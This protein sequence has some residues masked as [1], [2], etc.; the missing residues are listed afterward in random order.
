MTEPAT[1]GPT[2]TLAQVI[3]SIVNTSEVW[4]NIVSAGVILDVIAGTN[5]PPLPPFIPDEI[6]SGGV[7]NATDYLWGSGDI[8]SDLNGFPQD[9]QILLPKL[10]S[11]VDN[12]PISLTDYMQSNS[13]VMDGFPA[14]WQGILP[15]LKSYEDAHPESKV[16]LMNYIWGDSENPPALEGFPTEWQGLMPELK[17]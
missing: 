9:W 6:P 3:C 10:K 8:P 7:E 15:E 5:K 16:Q 4:A 2:K 11:Y 17:T 14:E 12:N 1:P 13:I